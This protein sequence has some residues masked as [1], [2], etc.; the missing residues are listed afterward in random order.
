MSVE[1]ATRPENDVMRLDTNIYNFI[2]KFDL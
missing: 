1:R 2:I